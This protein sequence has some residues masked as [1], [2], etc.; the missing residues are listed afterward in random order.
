MGARK[1][2]P[3]LFQG[4]VEEPLKSFNKGEIKRG[5][6][7]PK[8]LLLTVHASTSREAKWE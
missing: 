2:N 3:H 8:S 4:A 6:F 1:G 7:N 5:K